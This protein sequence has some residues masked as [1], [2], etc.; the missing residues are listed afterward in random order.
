MDALIDPVQLPSA[1]LA[2][3]RTIDFRSPGRD[4]WADED[5]L[6]RRFVASWAGIDDGAW[7]LPGAPPSDARGP[8]WSLQDH[9]G[10]LADWQE[11]A[12]EYVARAA[13]GGP[14]PS[15]DDD[16]GGDFD[17]FNE[18]HRAPWARLQPG[19]IRRRLAASHER[20]VERDG[21]ARKHLARLGPFAADPRR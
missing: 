21:H 11:L 18:G 10:H 5:A 17:R 20:L 16:E 1:P 3:L 9:V 4:F 13:A 7:S 6:W 15:D 19:A 2:L 14:W 12:V 8:D